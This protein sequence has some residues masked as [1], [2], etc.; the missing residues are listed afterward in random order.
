VNNFFQSYW[1]AK[2]VVIPGQHKSKF[3]HILS[4]SDIDELLMNSLLRFPEFRMARVDNPVD[5]S[6]YTTTVKIG[7]V[8]TS[9]VADVNRVLRTC[10]KITS[11]FYDRSQKAV[12]LLGKT[13]V[14]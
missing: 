8:D 1:E 13:P 14:I 7:G 3:N 9:H 5:M 10:V 2:P 6:A 11:V 4:F 12:E